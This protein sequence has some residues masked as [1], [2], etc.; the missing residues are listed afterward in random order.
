MAAQ[1]QEMPAA[2]SR[3]VTAAQGPMAVALMTFQ[4]TPGQLRT[5]QMP[6]ESRGVLIVFKCRERPGLLLQA[7]RRMFEVVVTP[8]NL[9]TARGQAHIE[10][11]DHQRFGSRASGRAVA[12][13]RQ[14]TKRRLIITQHQYMGVCTVAKVVV[15]ALFLAQPLDK[16]QVGFRVLHTERTRWVNHRPQFEGIGISKDAVLLKHCRDNLRHAALLE[17]PLV[18]TMGQVRHARRKGEVV[19]G[20]PLPRAFPANAVDLPVQAFTGLAKIQIGRLV[21]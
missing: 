12:L 20:Q 18:A 13:R 1:F 5:S 19:A 21:K 4:A 3:L 7:Q 10:T 9:S 2:Q 8:N 17:N 14:T 11:L 6:R 16:V 15:N